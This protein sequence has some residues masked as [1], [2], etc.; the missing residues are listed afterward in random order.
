MPVSASQVGSRGVGTP[1]ITPPMAFLR[2]HAPGLAAALVAP[3][4]STVPAHAAAP[5]EEAIRDWQRVAIRDAHVTRSTGATTPLAFTVTRRAAG[6]ALSLAYSTQDGSAVA[7]TDYAASTGS[8]AFAAGETR[9]TVEV[10][11]HARASGGDDLAFT[12]ALAGLAGDAVDVERARATGTIAN[13]AASRRIDGDLACDGGL[14]DIVVRDRQQL[15]RCLGSATAP[16][17]HFGD[18]AVTVDPLAGSATFALERRTVGS[19]VWLRYETVDG[20][21]RAGVDYV[22][23]SGAIELGPDRRRAFV[24]VPVDPSRIADGDRTFSLR[25]ANDGTP[26][27][28]NDPQLTAT[29]RHATPLAPAPPRVGRPLDGGVAADASARRWERCDADG[30]CTTIAGESGASY[31]PTAA[32]VGLRVRVRATVPGGGGPDL[33]LATPPSTPVRGLPAAPALAGGPAEG[34]ATEATRATFVLAGKEHDAAYECALD[35]TA[36]APC[37]AAGTVTL[38]GLAPGAHSFAVRQRTVDG[39]VSAAATRAWAVGAATPAPSSRDPHRPAP[40]SAGP[41]PGDGAPPAVRVNGRRQQNRHVRDVAAGRT[42]VV[43]RCGAPCALRAPLTI[44]GAAARRVGLSSTR[45]GTASGAGRAAG[46]VRLRVRLDA[47]A[48]VRLV[49]I[50]RPVTLLAHVRDATGAAGPVVVRFRLL[51]A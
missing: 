48:R 12:L 9:A 26:N 13:G 24:T 32:D 5:A 14:F 37:G 47:A 43:L 51:P 16:Y 28:P 17:A 45:V 3:L 7:G 11:V 42:N 21:A 23:T 33:L 15:V 18:R 22:A 1:P 34:T 4:L 29:I 31:A 46:L 38:D 35:G 25:V 30:G 10:P 49:R 8:V 40:P 20:T 44:S 6:P 36:F 19:P 50:G 41:P 39:L 27:P 2:T